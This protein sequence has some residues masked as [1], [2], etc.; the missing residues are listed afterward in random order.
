MDFEVCQNYPRPYGKFIL[1][2]FQIHI[3]LNTSHIL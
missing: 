2:W 1:D 3:K